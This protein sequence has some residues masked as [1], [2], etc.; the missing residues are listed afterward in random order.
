VI[1]SYRHRYGYA[2]GDPAVA[3]IEAKLARQPTIGVPTINL[4][5]DADGVGPASERDGNA[6]Q[7]T[8]GYERRMIAKVGHNVPQEAPA[9]TIAAMRDL[10]KTTKP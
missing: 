5:G 2:P 10:M 7:F 4:H 6:R 8:G 9:E 1:Q 3:H